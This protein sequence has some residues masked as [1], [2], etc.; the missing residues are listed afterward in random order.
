EKPGFSSRNGT[1]TAT[2]VLSPVT[3]GGWGAWEIAARVDRYDFTDA[4]KGG[5]A[6]STT[7]GV[8]WYFNN[9][10]RLMFEYVDWN[11][12]NKVGSY[13]GPDDGNSIGMRAQLAF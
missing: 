2:T 4:P 10:A 8:N 13:Q 12:N 1:W 9:W 7:F 5:D 3:S 11:T 6:H